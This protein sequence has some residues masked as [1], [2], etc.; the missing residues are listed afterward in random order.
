MYDKTF[1]SGSRSIKVLSEEFLDVA[2]R[3]NVPNELIQPVVKELDELS[4]RL[5]KMHSAL[6]AAR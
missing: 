5:I 1:I 2:R 3:E 6:N 4:E